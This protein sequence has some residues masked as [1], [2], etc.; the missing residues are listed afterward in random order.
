MNKELRRAETKRDLKAGQGA[1]WDAN[2]KKWTLIALA[3]DAHFPGIF[4]FIEIRN[5]QE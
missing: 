5:S 4:S 1:Q 3:N 2:P